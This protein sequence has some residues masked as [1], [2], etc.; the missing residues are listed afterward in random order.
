MSGSSPSSTRH[1]QSM[2]AALMARLRAVV[3]AGRRYAMME[4]A[5]WFVGFLAIA[6]MVQFAV[7]YGTGGLR[8]SMRAALLAAIVVAAGIVLWRYLVGPYRLRAG[9]ADAARLVERKYPQLGSV[10]IS[11]V[12][13]SAGQ[14]GSADANSR[15][16]M[17]STIVRAAHQAGPLDFGVVLDP[18]GARRAGATLAVILVVSAATG[19]AWPQEAGLWYARN[20]LL[21]DVPWPKR[22]RLVVECSDGI[23]ISARGDDLVVQAYAVGVQPREVEIHYNTTSGRRGRESMVTVGGQGDYRYRYTFKNAQEDFVFH[24]EGGDDRTDEY[25]ARLLERPAVEESQ[26]R[27]HPPDYTG[28]AEFALPAD[29][30]AAEVLRGSR[31]SVW[32]RTNHPV[33]RATLM[34][35][36]E[37]IAEVE[38]QDVGRYEVTFAPTTTRTYHVALVDSAGLEDRRPP[39]FS[40][41]VIKDQAP[42]ARLKVPGAGDMITPEAVLPIEV[43]YADVYGLATAELVYRILPDGPE[44]TLPL[45]SLPPRSTTF[46]ARLSWSVANEVVVAGQR[47]MLWARATDFDDVSGPNHADSPEITLRVVSRDELLAELSRR[48]HEIRLDFERLVDAQE[49][50]R[51]SLLT[52]IG[53][54]TDRQEPVALAETLTPIERRQRTLAGS[55]NVIRQQFERILTELRINQLDSADTVERLDQGIIEPLTELAKRDLPAAAEAIRQWSRDASPQTAALIDAQQVTLIQRL[56]NVLARMIQWEGYQEAVNMLR[57]IIRLQQELNKETSQSVEDQGSGVFDD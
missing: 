40:I 52:A 33:T 46:S 5:A 21:Q 32:I 8:W 3:T 27:V 55:L 1:A 37:V 9:A 2:D 25:Q 10:L 41:Q 12:R 36:R 39:P 29:Q 50:V 23:L 47:V 38:E 34:V 45:P 56:R 48:E 43:E 31:V 28:L 49:Q 44:G 15:G 54:F 20:V 14:V 18:R 7:D 17:A 35:D 30:R 57:D 26:I 4:G 42:S 13:F 22:T 16:L 51:G 11:A 6:A 19:V 53:R 24:L